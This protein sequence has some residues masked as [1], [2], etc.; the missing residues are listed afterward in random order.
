MDFRGRL[1]EA[2]SR[3]N[4]PLCIGIDPELPPLR[5][6]LHNES[7][8]LDPEDY[9]FFLIR[10]I[11]R[12]SEKLCH[13][14][15]FQSAFFESYGA[16]GF[17]ALKKG[18]ELAHQKNFFCILDAKRGD[19][20]ST[21]TA[22][23]RSAFDYLQADAL[24][25]TPYMGWDVIAPLVPWLKN[26]KGVFVVWLTSNSS[27]SETQDL[28][29]QQ[30]CLAPEYLTHMAKTLLNRAQGHRIQDSLGFVAG[31][32]RLETHGSVIEALG[33][34]QCFLLPGIGFQ[35]GSFS[36]TLRQLIAK[37][38]LSIIPISRGIVDLSSPT[39]EVDGWEGFEAAV[40]QNL[41]HHISEWTSP[42]TK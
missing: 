17:A 30:P 32:T 27:A 1:N 21:M 13:I 3:Q 5:S 7:V 8:R 28:F 29:L 40:G 34:A 26:G 24:T 42:V 37:N 18:I 6:F 38:P 16:K 31:V 33:P 2:L 10:S 36:A 19:I 25:V 41:T 22:Y 9:L 20:S 35:G 23:G 39:N 11:L 14:V 4:H 12:S 15:K